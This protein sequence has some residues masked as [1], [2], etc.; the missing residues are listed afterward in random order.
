[1]SRYA[2]QLDDGRTI[3]YGHDHA[4]G[5]FFQVFSAP[6][7][8]GETELELDECSTF[9]RMANGRMLE[10]MLDYKVNHEHCMKVG[11]DLEF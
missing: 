10:L 1:M 9:T 7:D 8:K 6:D 11:F 2:K 4:L 5:Y 3:A